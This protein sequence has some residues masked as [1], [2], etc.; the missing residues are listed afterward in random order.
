MNMIKFAGG[1]KRREMGRGGER[2][3]EREKRR[4]MGK[5]RELTGDKTS[6]KESKRGKIDRERR[7]I[8]G[9]K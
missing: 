2:G 7:Q 8:G 1:G 5:E 9:D 3:C 6:N 4:K